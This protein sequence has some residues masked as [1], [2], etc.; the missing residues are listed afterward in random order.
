ME[1]G[2]ALRS[3]DLTGRLLYLIKSKQHLSQLKPVTPCW[4][5]FITASSSY[6]STISDLDAV[7]GNPCTSP[8][9]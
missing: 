4:L 8:G 2:F 1:L 6:I 9:V 5:D 7:K 3:A